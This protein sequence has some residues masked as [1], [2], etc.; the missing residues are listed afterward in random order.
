MSA[1]T[2]KQIAKLIAR[3]SENLPEMSGEVMQGWIENPKALRRFL[4]ELNFSS[5]TL[6]RVDH[7]IKPIYP[8]WVKKVIHPELE[9]VNHSE[10]DIS[11]IELYL[12]EGGK[13]GE[14][15]GHDI[16]ANLKTG[17]IL[18]TCLGLRD[19][20]EIRGKGIIFFKKHFKGKT[21]CGWKGVVEDLD[22]DYFVPC[23]READGEVLLDWYDLD[24]SF[25]PSEFSGRFAS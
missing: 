20:E 5:D 10:Y 9:G 7:S 22:G 19:L 1:K 24:Y 15:A 2:C 21:I 14:I 25:S 16:Y 11:Q 13:K 3:I 4:L 12:D 18:E 8:D 23:I 6:I 17:E